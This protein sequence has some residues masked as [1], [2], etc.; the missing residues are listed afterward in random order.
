MKDQV[1]ELNTYP[2]TTIKDEIVRFIID[3]YD[4]NRSYLITTHLND[5]LSYKKTLCDLNFNTISNINKTFIK[6]LTNKVFCRSS[7]NR[8]EIFTVIENLKHIDKRTH[9]H[10]IVSTPEHLSVEMMIVKITQSVMN[11][12]QLVDLNI[13]PLN[14]N[15]FNLVHYLTKQLQKEKLSLED[16]TIDW[17][18]C[19][20]T[21]SNYLAVNH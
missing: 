18:N 15:A 10:T 2:N 19:Y 11:T 9:I 14:D 6:K 12:E 7:K 4:F 21:K 3:N 13:K 17:E 1:T 20:L 5:S 16:D 8:L